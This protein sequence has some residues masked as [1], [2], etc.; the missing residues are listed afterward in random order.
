V[1]RMWTTEQVTR[2]ME[3]ERAE[4]FKKKL[5]QRAQARGRSEAVNVIRDAIAAANARYAEVL[6][7]VQREFEWGIIGPDGQ[8]KKFDR[9]Q[10]IAQEVR[11][12]LLDELNDESPIR[13]EE[14]L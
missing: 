5:E 8:P 2:I 3:N 13:E 9:R 10:W 11:R 6:A 14:E 12:R 1:S 4:V 7:R